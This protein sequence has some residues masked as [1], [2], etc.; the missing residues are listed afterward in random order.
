MDQDLI[1]IILQT[2]QVNEDD[3]VYDLGSGDGRT[4]ITAALQFH[5]TAVGIE[6]DRL[7]YYYSLYKRFILRLGNK[8]T[9]LHKNIFEV[10]LSPA[11]VVV[12]YLL[13]ATNEALMKKLLTELKPG[14]LIIS[15]AFNFPDWEPVFVDHDHQTP[16]GPI[17]YYQV[18]EAEEIAQTP[19]PEQS[20]P[21]VNQPTPQQVPPAPQPS[22]VP[23]EE[24]Q[25]V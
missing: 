23:T 6:I 14:T 2:A 4:P 13:P 7:R 18:E 12:V 21:A 5:A 20:Q 11:T 10:D 19:Q 9:F 15:G 8:V 22:A 3:V 25:V 24:P 16:F 1:E 17:Y